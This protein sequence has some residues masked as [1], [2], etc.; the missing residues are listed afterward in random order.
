MGHDAVDGVVQK[1]E[2]VHR[3]LVFLGNR[4]EL[5]LVHIFIIMIVI[6]YALR[7]ATLP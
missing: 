3:L 1:R 6:F 5:Q 7:I 4:R 2:S